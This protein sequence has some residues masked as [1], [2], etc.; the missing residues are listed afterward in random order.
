MNFF[1]GIHPD[2]RFQTPRP[3]VYHGTKLSKDLSRNLRVLRQAFGNSADVVFR[4]IPDGQRP[5]IVMLYIDGLVDAKTLDEVVLEPLIYQG[6]PQGIKHIK[7]V[8]QMLD[9][10]LIAVSDTRRAA[11]ISAILDQVL[12]A[13]VALL[14]EGQNEALMANLPGF[15]KR[16]VEESKVESSLR[17]PRD[18]FTE[19]IRVN[20]SLIRRKLKY[21]GPKKLDTDWRTVRLNYGYEK[22][23]HAR[24]QSSSRQRDLS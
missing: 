4:C 16:A 3:T 5:Q 1:R 15:E 21:S 8:A 10:G 9:A 6:L 12:N 22:T 19:S 14:F 7:N 23:V 2:N 13:S 11:H 18:G 24:I 20:T 17:G